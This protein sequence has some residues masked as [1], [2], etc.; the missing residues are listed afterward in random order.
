M[1]MGELA[2]GDT[3]TASIDM[4]KRRATMY[5][6]SATHLMHA[7]LRQVLG[8]HVQQKG[9]LVDENRLRFDFSHYEAVTPEQLQRIEDIVND[10]IRVNNEVKADVM[11]MDDA[12]Q[13]GAMMLFGEKYGDEV[14]VLSMGDFSIELCGGTHV[15]RTGDIGLFKVISESGVAAGVRRIEAVTGAGALRLIREQ[16]LQLLNINQLMK[17]ST[18]KVADKVAQ[19]MDKNRKLEKE[20]EQLKGKLASAAGGDLAS[21][22]QDINGV[23]VVAAKLEGADA[24]S[25]RD[26]VDQLKNKLGSAAVVLAVVQDDKVSLCAGVTRDQTGSVKAGD[27]VNFVA[28]QVGGKGGG[29]PDMAMAGGNDASQ[30]ET[31]LAS[32]AGWV[33]EQL[34]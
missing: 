20:L 30:L 8:E 7:A 5:N 22:A 24:K 13:T 3:V 28:Q 6:H 34:N 1:A 33:Q 16:E 19:L 23:K 14:R 9:S 31:A 26:T 29:R 2:V 25:L 4:D 10:Q 32:V 21:D 27:L 12:K 18:G 15:S 11:T 17:G